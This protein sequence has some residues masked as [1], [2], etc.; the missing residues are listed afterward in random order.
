[1]TAK[2]DIQS[3]G[4]IEFQ[5][6]WNRLIAVVEEQAQALRRTAFSPIV[7][8]SGDL[9]AGFFHPDGRMIAQAVTG[10]PGHVNTMAASVLHF[11]DRFPANT[12]REGDVYITNDPWMGT[13]HL[14]DF[15]AVT[16]AFYK[17]RMVGLFASTC[18]FM[19][20]GGIGFG[21]D[22]R[23]VFEEGFYVPPMPMIA[24]GEI[25]TTLITLARSNSR[26]PAELEGDLMSLAAC[27]Q[28]G[29]NR[30]ADMLDEFKL[31]DL[32][33]LCNQIVARSREAALTAIAKLP[34]GSAEAEMTIDGYD[35]PVTLK[36][37]TRIDA[38]H[39]TVD[40]AG[41]SGL[42]A[43]GINVPLSY[44]QAYS[45][46]AIAC[47]LFPEVPNNSGS[48]SVV[49]VSAPDNTIVNALRPAPVSSRHVIGQ[50]LPDV[51]YGCLARLVPQNVL[52]EGAS[53]LWNLIL[54]DAHDACLTQGIPAT[55]R[56]S[57]LSV[58]TGGTGARSRLD[59]LNAT[60][61]PSGV[62]GVPIEILETLTPLIFWRKELRA[63]SGGAGEFRGGLGQSIEIGH[64]DGH[65]FYIYAALDRI[66][67]PA[68]GRFGGESG[69]PGKVAL[70]A[71]G[72]LKGKGKQLVPTGDRLIVETPGGGGYGDPAKR[73][74][75]SL[76]ADRRNG[77]TE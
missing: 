44:A 27:N 10:T 6:M 64:R 38:D 34:R 37:S 43:R 20:V 51:V 36:A 32:T 31:T 42:S 60:A 77:F 29:V 57:A 33:P 11:L 54:E 45:T 63:G 52:A 39:I 55:R 59:G 75:E 13:G 19:D 76:A 17:G 35:R 7:R 2:S 56:F 15:V 25:N 21:P 73:S 22:G 65:P 5:I 9:S 41:T 74:E 50:M 69:A 28:I 62:S 3:I 71:G 4:E 47:A 30:L 46:Y 12:M 1:M 72:L 16:P 53:A 14:H 24:A 61:F 48:L 66:Q 18:H 49:T 68:R 8:E 23:D 40:F 58:Q 26:Y 70:K 67:N